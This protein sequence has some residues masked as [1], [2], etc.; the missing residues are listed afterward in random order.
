MREITLFGLFYLFTTSVFSQLSVS[1]DSRMDFSWDKEK[2]T[3]EF[4]NEDP[5][6]L[7]FFE[8][9]EDFTMI[10]H[11]TSN[12]TS[13]YMIKSQEHDEEEG[14]NQYIFMVT[15]DVGNKYMMI[16]D[17]ENGNIRFITGD[18]S[19]MIKYRIKSSWA[20]E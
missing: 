18:F 17:V 20:D 6:A 4:Q 10:K 3:W 11:T 2:E 5:E 9:N 16:Y 13:A 19:S 7:T 14:R 1:T 15:S 8:F 12:T